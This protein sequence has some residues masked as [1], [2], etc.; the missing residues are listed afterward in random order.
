MRTTI[1]RHQRKKET[2]RVPRARKEMTWK[3]GRREFGS[4]LG[5]GLG[6]AIMERREEKKEERKDIERYLARL[7]HTDKD[8]VETQ[9]K[10]KPIQKTEHKTRQ[11][12]TRPYD[13]KVETTSKTRRNIARHRQQDNNTRTRKDQVFS[14]KDEARQHRQEYHDQALPSLSSNPNNPLPIP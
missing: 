13:T 11:D 10:D 12:Q 5:F 8:Q 6:L 14:E 2:E 1:W 4:G 7:L 9:E 3:E